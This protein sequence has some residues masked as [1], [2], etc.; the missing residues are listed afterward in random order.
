LNNAI[1]VSVDY[2]Y[3]KY[4][5]S[6]IDSI[7]TIET[8]IDIFVRLVDFKDLQIDEI[9]KKYP[10]IKLI[11]DNPK[12]S[13]IKNIFKTK[14]EWDFTDYDIQKIT[15]V[16]KVLCSPRGY[17]SCHSRFLSIEELLDKG[18]NVL[19]LDAD[20]LFL[21]NFDDIFNNLQYDIY[22]VKD[23]NICNINIFSNEGFLL[24]KNNKKIKNYISKI[25]NY[26]FSGEKYMGWNVDNYALHKFLNNDISVKLLDSKYKDKTLNKNSVMWSGTG[27]IKYDE[28]FIKKCTDVNKLSNYVE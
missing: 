19:S 7:Q 23:T 1:T 8:K 20:T 2:N 28:S 13:G 22:T 17:Y 25:N 16:K 3:I 11:I 24:F 4:L 26:I 12:L 5:Y 18:Y 14:D 6:F 27:K 21:K 15:D 10:N 9:K